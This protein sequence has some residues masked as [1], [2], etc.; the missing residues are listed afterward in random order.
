MAD[1]D[2]IRIRTCTGCKLALPATSEFFH[3]HKRSPDGCRAV[4]RAC[5]AKDHAENR[6]SRLAPRRVHYQE[7]KDR[8]KEVNR[9]YYWKNPEANRAAAVKRHEKN[10]DA[11]LARMN[12]YR[13]AH[14]DEINARRRVAE[15]GR[16][17]ARY[18]VDPV[19]TLKHRVRSLIRRTISAGRGGRRM[20]QLLGYTIQELRAHI[21]R[22]FVLGMNWDRFF[23]GDIH[24]DHILPVSHFNPRAYDSPEFKEC[25]ALSNLRPM[26]AKDNWS[27]GDSR[28]FLL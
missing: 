10:R 17:Q 19:F 9:E 7:N 20:H 1:A 26:W 2:S 11:N 22:Q 13:A 8:L 3:A 14:K 21:E 6:E 24:I 16:F 12:A 18:K 15:V 5:R 28:M 4:C 23:A 25:W 27:K